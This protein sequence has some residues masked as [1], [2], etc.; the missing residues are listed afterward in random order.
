M[1]AIVV[2]AE[3]VVGLTPPAQQIARPVASPG[4][5]PAVFAVD[6]EPGLIISDDSFYNSDA[7]TE[8]EIQAFFRAEGCAP[9]DDSPCLADYREST[10]TLPDDN[11]NCRSYEGAESER[12]SAIV[13]K[14]AQACGISPRVL[15]VLLQKEQSLLTAPSAYGYQRA[16]GYACPDT[17][18]CDAEFFGFFNQVYKAAWQFREYA[19][20]ADPWKFRPGERSVAYNPDPACGASPVHIANQATANLYNYTPYQPDAAVLADP[21]SGDACGSHGNLNFFTIWYAWFGSPLAERF[22]SWWGGCLDHRG[23][24]SCGY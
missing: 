10:R 7:M 18:P 21:H 9:K 8:A 19:N 2:T 1:L 20:P 16:T 6:F 24:S 3:L 23:G 5:D 22:P 12:A 11:G 4:V 15:I 14:V 13:Y 17:K